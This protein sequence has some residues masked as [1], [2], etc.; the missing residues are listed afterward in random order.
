MSEL[1]LAAFAAETGSHLVAEPRT[2]RYVRFRREFDES[3]YRA[4]LR[5]RGLRFVGRSAEEFPALLSAIGTSREHVSEELAF[6]GV[7]QNRISEATNFGEKLKLRQVEQLGAVVDSD[8]AAAAIEL[9]QAD[10]Q[11]QTSLQ[12]RA[13]I[14]SRSLFDYIG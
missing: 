10:L 13:K 1:V 4:G 3:A 12:A 11:R 8:F 6:Y 9:T 5:A 7:V 14:T 2:E